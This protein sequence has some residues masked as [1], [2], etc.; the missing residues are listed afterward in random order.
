MRP[1]VVYDTMLFLQAAS[2]PDRSHRTMQAVRDGRLELCIS[3]SLL[4]EI[5]DV[6]TR[7]EHV[8]RFPAMTGTVVD[9][10]LSDILRYSRFVEPVPQAFTWTRHPDDDHVFDL[11]IAAGARFLVTWETRILGLLAEQSDDARRL[12]ALAPQL[13]IITPKDLA[14]QLTFS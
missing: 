1:V 11:T 10:F 3:A 8:Q 14:A 2:R 12:L 13:T 9:L 5:R 4:A 7:P 6:L